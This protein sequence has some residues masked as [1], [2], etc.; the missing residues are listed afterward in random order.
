MDT[1][2]R[3]NVTRDIMTRVERE[4]HLFVVTTRDLV[5]NPEETRG[6]RQPTKRD[7]HQILEVNFES[8]PFFLLERVIIQTEGNGKL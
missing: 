8:L 6:L 1:S 2:T 7:L 4:K 3:S 5:S